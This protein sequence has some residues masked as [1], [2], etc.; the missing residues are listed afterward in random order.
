MNKSKV[1]RYSVTM[2]LGGTFLLVLG[3][4]LLVNDFI[5][6]GMLPCL[7]GV[8]YIFVVP[9]TIKDENNEIKKLKEEEKTQVENTYIHFYKECK[10]RNIVKFLDEES[11]KSAQLIARNCGLNN[12]ENVQYY[13]EQGEKIIES[14]KNAEEEKKRASEYE[15]IVNESDALFTNEERKSKLIGKDKYLY[16]LME[17]CKSYETRIKIMQDSGKIAESMITTKAQTSDWAI[18]G[19]MASG[20]AGSAAGVATA[21]EIQRKNEQAELTAARIREQGKELLA[22]SKSS[23]VKTAIQDM[24][25]NLD[26]LEKEIKDVTNKLLDDYDIEELFKKLRVSVSKNSVLC[27]KFMEIV[28]EHDVESGIKIAGADA[29]LDGSVLIEVYE[30]EKVIG[31]GYYC[32]TGFG[33]IDFSKVG[34]SATHE[35]KAICKAKRGAFDSS[36]K[37][38]FKITPIALWMIEK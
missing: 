16:K 18:A 15:K 37:Y 13:Y 5:C 3:V 35:G 25:R 21:L 1:K 19:G 32:A 26:C 10:K 29:V 24:I 7:L 23:A 38:E 28:I 17:E 14:R 31:K 30:N 9:S 12:V 36:K 8:I 22:L 2:L 11:L 20:L 33:E 27:D 6:L 34:F 4:C